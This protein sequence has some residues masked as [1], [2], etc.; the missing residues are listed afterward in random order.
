MSR[1][2]YTKTFGKQFFQIAVTIK[3]TGKC[4]PGY[5]YLYAQRQ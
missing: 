5:L 2:R 3:I 1:A 4:T